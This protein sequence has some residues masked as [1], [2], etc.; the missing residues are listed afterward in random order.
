MGEKES[1][2]DRVSVVV[3]AFNAEQF[4][5]E[6]LV[7]ILGQT[8]G[9]LEI[10]AVDDGSTDGTARVI[11][12]F[13]SRVRYL[14]QPNSGSCSSPRNR[15]LEQ[16]RGDYI[17]FFDADDIMYPQKIEQQMAAIKNHSGAAMVVGD[18]ENFHGDQLHPGHFKTCPGLSRLLERHS[19]GKG[20]SI[21]LQPRQT[22]G[23]L[24]RENFTIAGS[25]LYVTQVVRQLGGYDEELAACEDFFLNYRIASQFPTVVLNA[26]GNRRRL[27]AAN[28]T[29]NS[30][31]MI[32]SY[33]RSRE[34]LLQIETNRENRKMLKNRLALYHLNFANE[35]SGNGK[36]QRIRQ[37]WQSLKYLPHFDRQQFPLLC[38]A[39]A[40]TLL[41]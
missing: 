5:G 9:N 37:L 26:P 17:N 4:I 18:Y 19:I 41:K 30:S 7:S 13:G 40:K 36:S 20:E 28:L 38:R 14:H 8:W 27:H 35:V 1:M 23:L 16:A 34:K 10:I 2:Q 39:A 15:G 32:R 25:T 31:K 22:T 29:G 11:K 33:I 21:L 24:L 6:A 12:Q 3:P